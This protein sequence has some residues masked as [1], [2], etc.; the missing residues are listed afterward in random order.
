M[1]S[2]LYIDDDA[3]LRE[4]GKQFLEKT[5]EFT[6][7]TVG[8]PGE[9]LKSDDLYW[10]DAIISDYQMPGT[11]GIELLRQIRSTGN[12]IPF[13]LFTNK[14]R[15]EVV[16][17]ALNEGAD[18]YIRKG[19]EP[20][21]QFAELTHKLRIAVQRQQDRL[22]IRENEKVQRALFRS[23]VDTAGLDSLKKITQNISTWLE[24]DSVMI[25]ERQ[26]DGD[27]VKV[28]AMV[29][30]GYAVEDFSYSLKGT[31]CE[32]VAEKGF[33]IFPD[34]AQKLFPEAV[35]L[36]TLNIR[37]YAGTP[38]RSSDGKILGILCILSRKPLDVNR[39]NRDI[40]D[41][42]AVKA[43]MEIERNRAEEALRGSEEKYRLLSDSAEDFIYIIDREDRVVYINRFGLTMLNKNEGDIIGK[44]RNNLFPEAVAARQYNS[45]RE[46]FT[47]GL[48]VRI[49]SKIP[50]PD[51][52]SWQD[53]QLVPIRSGNGPVT[54]VLGISRDITD[55]RM[56]EMALRDNLERYSL[57][58]KNANEGIMI[59]ELTPQG[60]GTFIE[61]NDAA[62]RILGLTREELQNLSPTDLGSAELGA[63][64]ME[65]MRAVQKN[66][67]VI[68]QAN[69]RTKDNR[70]K[71]LE[72]S[73]SLFE[74]AGRPTILSVVHDITARKKNEQALRHA[75]KK[76]NLMTSITR[77]D[78][79]NQLMGLNTY[80]SLSKDSLGDAEKTGEYIRR[81]EGVTKAIERQISFTKEYENLGVHDP[82]W[83]NVQQCIKRAARELD[84]TGI[85]LTLGEMEGVEIFADSLLQKVFF[86]LIDNSL[87]H[88]GHAL[89]KIR[90]SF[91][92]TDK[93]LT[94]VFDNDGAGIPTSEKEVI[95]E[96]GYGKNTGFGL[97]FIK[98][99]LAITRIAIR[100]NGEPEKGARFEI[101]VPKGE[102]RFTRGE[103]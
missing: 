77:H 67:H 17:E 84:L 46:V 50:L 101:H 32:D 44:P 9:V 41:I 52:E 45:I 97:F 63:G 14:G 90:F 7:T 72:I 48:P 58:L 93:G 64:Y 103:A 59:N 27:S 74:H 56:A 87:R 68:F 13:I 37:G 96:R 8:S 11:N 5:G 26:P 12:T 62:C 73:V 3:V 75:N 99:I 54:A 29:L 47:T 66:R 4:T 49:E 71:F 42:F 36:S 85:V 31:P 38:L 80:L 98:E 89:E 57:I 51:R 95:F 69:H 24:V 88:G 22:A 65:F 39:V 60:P 35:D 28:L 40:M 16:I 10:Y 79:R 82:V 83:Q 76:L 25:G 23:L 86:N 6:I 19:G 100:E 70:E 78:I 15:E 34:N 81:E 2:V 43:S 102:Y 61:V 21:A 53:T 55:R 91:Q 1:I 18:F 30:D 20:E 33:C 92:E 94:I